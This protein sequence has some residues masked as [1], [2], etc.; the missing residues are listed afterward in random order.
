MAVNV[1]VHMSSENVGL[2]H[3]LQQNR[4]WREGTPHPSCCQTSCMPPKPYQLSPRKYNYVFKRLVVEKK[5]LKRPLSLV[6]VIPMLVHG[7]KK[8]G[9]WP[10]DQ[11]AL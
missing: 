11:K 3:W 9:D 1:V 7:W 6:D 5:P 8:T 4:Q 10:T 2:A